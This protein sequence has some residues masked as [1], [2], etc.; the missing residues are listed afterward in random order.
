MK[1]ALISVSDKLGVVELA[2]GLSALG[3]EIISTG[4]TGIM[5]QN[6]GIAVQSIAEVTGFPE[7]LDGRLKTLHPKIHGGILASRDN[8]DHMAQI[9]ALDIALIDIVAVNLYP[10]KQTIRKPGVT[11]FD[12][13]ENVDIGG[14]AMIRAAAKNY[15]DVTVL[16]DPADYGRIL[17]ELQ[18]TGLVCEQTRFELCAKVFA[19]TAHYDSLIAKYAAEQAG[20]S[21][22]GETLTLTYERVQDMRYGENPHQKAAFYKE[23]GDTSGFLTDIVQLHGKELSF[24]NINDT[25]GALELLKEYSAPTVVACKHS[26]PCGVGSASTVCEAYRKAYNADPVSVFGGI[27]VCNREVNAEAAAEMSRIFLEIVLAPSFTDEAFSILSKKKNLRI[28]QL[29]DIARRQPDD[30]LDLK[31]VSGGLLVQ[32]INNPI[33]PANTAPQTVTERAPTPQE[34]ADL[35]FAWKIV[36]YVKSNG[37]A[38]GK[39]E[40]SIGIGLGQVNRVR[41]TKQAIAHAAEALGAESLNGAALASDAYFPFAD[42]VEA[43]A[44]AGITAIIQPGGSVNDQASIDACNAHGIAMVFTGMRHFRH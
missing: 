43:A 33:L 19:H 20:I 15:K 6:A 28:L 36:K 29:P 11:L 44:A 26:N 18:E 13:M 34:M 24:N 40:Q 5:L 10:F 37:I 32:N 2:Q 16:V 42:C 25:N 35:L 7:G 23:V 39:H 31:K 41:A 9:A 30:T 17:A 8:A 21:V 27:V 22:P 38:I 14:P 3:Y 12:A 4:G 1:R